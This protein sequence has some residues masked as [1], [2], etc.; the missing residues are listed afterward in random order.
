LAAALRPLSSPARHGSSNWTI[1]VE[2]LYTDLGSVNNSI[3]TGLVPVWGTTCATPIVG[4]TTFYSSIHVHEQIL[5]VGLNY[6]FKNP[7]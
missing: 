6:R 5:R 3:V 7:H 2:Y 1:K 4:T